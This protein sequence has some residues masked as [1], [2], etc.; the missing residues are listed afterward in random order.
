VPI[1]LTQ[2]RTGVTSA[3]ASGAYAVKGAFSSDLGRFVFLAGGKPFLRV[4]ASGTDEQ[5]AVPPGGVVSTVTISGDGRFAAVDWF[6]D[7]GG[8]SRAFRVGL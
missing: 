6:P 7:D 5:I 1:H 8:P 2:V 4:L 3:V